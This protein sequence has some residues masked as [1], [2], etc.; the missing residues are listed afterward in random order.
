MTKRRNPQAGAAWNRK[1]GP[2]S[3]RRRPTEPEPDF[4]DLEFWMFDGIA[5][6]TDGCRVEPDGVCEHGHE[7]WL[8]H[9][10][11]I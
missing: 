5:E 6:A 1:A 7:S 8:L 4:E 3:E 9:L 11:L 2:M 10:G